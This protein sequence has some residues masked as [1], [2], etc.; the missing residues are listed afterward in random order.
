MNK[1]KEN[2]IT[3][4]KKFI[5]LGFDLMVKKILGNS[6]KIE[7][8]KLLLYYIF[9][10]NPKKI[11]ILNTE[12]LERPYKDK[13]I[14]VDLIVEVDDNV[15]INLESN[16]KVVQ[17]TIDRNLFYSFR[18][19]ST[20][21]KPGEGFNTLKQY[22]QLNIDL[23]GSHSE[24][25]STYKMMNVNTHEVLSEVITVV[26]VD[27]PYFRKMCYTN[28]IDKLDE[29]SKFISLFGADSMEEVNKLCKGNEVLEDIAKDIEKYNEDLDIIGA[30]DREQRIIEEAR[31][32]QR[33]EDK[34]EMEKA[35]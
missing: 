25:I 22:I 15:K 31:I 9:G 3:S 29:K 8:I 10:I 2:I 24:P 5:P 13:K 17:E 20:S 19:I 35:I 21:I 28:D 4:N 32:G 14:Y 7:R 16:S 6:E 12:I 30:Y 34:A 27:V 26:R 1:L 11:T 18:N 23:E 33:Y